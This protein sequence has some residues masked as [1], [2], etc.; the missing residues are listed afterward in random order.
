MFAPVP[1]WVPGQGSRLPRWS[2]RLCLGDS[3]FWRRVWHLGGS[4][5]DC[6]ADSGAAMQVNNNEHARTATESNIETIL[7]TGMELDALHTYHSKLQRCQK[8]W[9][10]SSNNILY[11]RHS[12]TLFTELDWK[13]T[14]PKMLQKFKQ[15]EFSWQGNEK[16]IETTKQSLTHTI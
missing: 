14:S 6:G 11:S 3:L 15:R 9:E 2:R 16:T 4:F 5:D 1:P 8:Q 10:I 7:K 12:S 13:S